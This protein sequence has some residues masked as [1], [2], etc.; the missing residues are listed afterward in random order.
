MDNKQIS[1][2]AHNAIAKRYYELYKDD[3]SDLKYFDLFLL[4]VKL[5]LLCPLQTSQHKIV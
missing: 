4:K 1:K 5:Y 2:E 3:T